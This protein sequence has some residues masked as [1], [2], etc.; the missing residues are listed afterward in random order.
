MCE[1]LLP[2]EDVVH[3][4][5]IP[6]I[7]P[8]CLRNSSVGGSRPIHRRA[9]TETVSSKLVGPGALASS[10]TCLALGFREL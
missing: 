10:I 9:N 3:R 4:K 2:E 8:V 1:F 6:Y 7:T 5:W